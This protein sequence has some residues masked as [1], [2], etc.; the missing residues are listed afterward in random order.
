[1]CVHMG[2][3]I[4]QNYSVQNIFSDDTVKMKHTLFEITSKP[5]AECTQYNILTKIGQVEILV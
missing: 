5:M 4:K 2:T 1:M 3:V